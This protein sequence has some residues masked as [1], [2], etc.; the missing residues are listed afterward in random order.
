MLEKAKD[1][2]EIYGEIKNTVSRAREDGEKIPFDYEFQA[3]EFLN[4]EFS[5]KKAAY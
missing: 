2:A 5:E 1:F 4:S 3:S